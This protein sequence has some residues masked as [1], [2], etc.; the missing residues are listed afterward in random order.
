MQ[1][2]RLGISTPALMGMSMATKHYIAIADRQPDEAAWSITF[3]D[4][5]GVT[6]VASSFAE[7]MRQARDALA[8]AVDDMTHENEP[9]PRAVEDGT[10]PRYDRATF[11]D[12]AI[13]LVPVE[14]TGRSLRINISMDESLLSRVDDLS[15]RIGL[16]RSA[17]LA[18]GARAVI[19]A[20]T[21][22]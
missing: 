12:P 14:A 16:S 19:A 11:H 18:R 17:L 2:S 10:T 4:F 6:S 5:P 8:S 20:E 1:A 22:S 15:K 9:L 7:T 3:P 13:L 21:A